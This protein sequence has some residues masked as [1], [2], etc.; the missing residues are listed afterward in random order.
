[1]NGLP[2]L[3]IRRNVRLVKVEIG[4]SPARSDHDGK[5]YGSMLKRSG[6]LARE[7]MSNIDT[8]F[9]IDM[10]R[11]TC[12]ADTME[13]VDRWLEREEREAQKR[14]QAKCDEVDRAVERDRDIANERDARESEN[15]D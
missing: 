15:G 14:I 5:S 13:A 9:H 7:A 6:M 2:A 3:N 10:A 8:Q 11:S 4:I 1:M 12:L